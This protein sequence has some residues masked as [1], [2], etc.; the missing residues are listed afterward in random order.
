[1][2]IF[3]KI[4]IIG[5]ILMT[6]GFVNAQ[7]VDNYGIKIGVGLSNQYWE[8][9]NS[10]LSDLSEWN[11][12]K[13]SFT[14][15]IYA[16]KLFGKYISLRPVFGYIQKGFVDD[17]TFTT[18]DGEELAI[19]D[20]KVVLHDLSLDLSIKV[21]PIQKSVKPYILLGLR[22]DYLMDYRSVIVDF[23]GEDYELNTDL[24]DDFNKL[25]IGGLI[26]IGLSYNNL[27][28]IDFEYN[29]AIT[30]NFE[31]DLLVIHDKYF[32][33]TLGLNINQLIN[34]KNE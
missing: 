9:K 6:N 7:I 17:I 23:Q 10:M 31:S 1:M 14:G 32:S 30:K 11:E 5:L 4:I 22:G 3:K 20:N 12:N 29:P 24:Y 21:I 8:F 2:K 34:N 18:I 19:K 27:M 33:L 13:I 26:G 16:E 28:F 25:T 15:Q